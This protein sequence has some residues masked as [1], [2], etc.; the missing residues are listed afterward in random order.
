MITTQIILG[1]LTVFIIGLV[2]VFNRHSRIIKKI[3]FAVEYRDSLLRW[4]INIF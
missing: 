2:L 4:L 1:I 3:E